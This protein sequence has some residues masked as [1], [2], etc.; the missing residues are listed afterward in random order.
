LSDDALVKWTAAGGVIAA[1]AGVGVALPPADSATPPEATCRGARWAVKTLSDSRAKLVSFKTHQTTV[2][3]LRHRRPPRHRNARI[4][5][6]ETTTYRVRASL[7]EWK[8]QGDGDIHLVI[9]DP[10]NLAETMIVE[11]PDQGCLAHSRNR[12]AM[13]AARSAILAACGAPRRTSF[14]RLAGSAS[15]KGVGFFD[16]VHGQPGVAPNGIELHPV[17]GF[18][19]VSCGPG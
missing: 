19:A 10:R 17:L 13:I 16:G 8:Q 14:Q 1:I 15:V 18:R 7:I 9:A 4:R 11:F 2:R 3:S 5:G 6:V 12:A